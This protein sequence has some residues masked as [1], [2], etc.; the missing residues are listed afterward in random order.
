MILIVITILLQSRCRHPHPG[1]LHCPAVS[2]TTKRLYRPAACIGNYSG[3][4][5][6]FSIKE[7]LSLCKETVNFTKA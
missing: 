4:V 7:K 5:P 6:R 3:A 1:V 2:L